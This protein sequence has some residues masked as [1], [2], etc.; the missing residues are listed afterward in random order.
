M[1]TT[2]AT[3]TARMLHCSTCLA[4]DVGRWHRASH[5]SSSMA[6][7]VLAA[8]WEHSVVRAMFPRQGGTEVLHIRPLPL[9]LVQ[10]R[11]AISVG[12]VKERGIVIGLHFFTRILTYGAL[13]L[14]SGGC[15]LVPLESLCGFA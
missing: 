14:L 2:M 11:T 9:A 15:L 6:P 13:V 1:T 3:T 8:L 7:L 4:D 12:V 5:R 10:V